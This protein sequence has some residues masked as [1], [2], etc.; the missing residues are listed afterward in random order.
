MDIFIRI[1]L[2]ATSLSI[3][4]LLR[5]HFINSL[6]PNPTI[7]DKSNKLRL[8]ICFNKMIIHKIKVCIDRMKTF[9]RIG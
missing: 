6:P 8:G 7:F 5:I 1:R 3:D 4:L 2:S 9:L